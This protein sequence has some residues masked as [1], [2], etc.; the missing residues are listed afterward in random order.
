MGSGMICS[1]LITASIEYTSRVH[2]VCGQWKIVSI[3]NDE[4]VRDANPI[5]PTI[6]QRQG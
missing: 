2:I 1:G 4:M 6:F 3:I 5:T